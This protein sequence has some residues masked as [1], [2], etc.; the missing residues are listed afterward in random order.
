MGKIQKENP[1]ILEALKELSTKVNRTDIENLA[2]NNPQSLLRKTTK[3]E[4]KD[5]IKQPLEEIKNYGTLSGRTLRT[6][7]RLSE[8]AF[9]EELLKLKKTY[10]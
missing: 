2:S 9:E 4:V 7:A 3:Q 6:L 5:F 1:E 8:E 10:F